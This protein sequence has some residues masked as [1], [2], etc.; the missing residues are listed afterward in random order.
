MIDVPPNT[1][2]TLYKLSGSWD[3]HTCDRGQSPLV[4]PPTNGFVAVPDGY[5]A[6]QINTSKALQCNPTEVLKIQNSTFNLSL[7]EDLVESGLHIHVDVKVPGYTLFLKNRECMDR[8]NSTPRESFRLKSDINLTIILQLNLNNLYISVKSSLFHCQQ[9]IPIFSVIAEVEV[10]LNVTRLC[11]VNIVKI[12]PM[13]LHGGIFCGI[14]NGKIGGAISSQV[15]SLIDKELQ[16]Y[17][18]KQILH[19]ISVEEMGFN[20]EEDNSMNQDDNK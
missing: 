15:Q 13:D 8:W 11:S 5:C 14:V 10:Y 2:V 1:Q 16:P 12:D 19:K 3:L 4:I 9:Q 20:E 6:M 18:G 7:Q 17:C